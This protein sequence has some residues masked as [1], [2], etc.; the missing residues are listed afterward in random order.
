[1][2][3]CMFCGTVDRLLYNPIIDIRKDYP[4]GDS[5]IHYAHINCIN[6]AAII[7]QKYQELKNALKVIKD[8]S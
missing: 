5:N 6:E 4:N 7:K 8:G 1:M 2:K 3:E